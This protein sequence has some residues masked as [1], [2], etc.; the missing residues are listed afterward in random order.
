[1]SPK[2]KDESFENMM[3][4]F[5][6]KPG[7]A[8]KPP[9]IDQSSL[10]DAHSKYSRTLNDLEAL[11]SK[12]ET[13]L[14]TDFEKCRLEYF[15]VDYLLFQLPK[16]F[17]PKKLLERISSLKKNMDQ[18]EIQSAHQQLDKRHKEDLLEAGKSSKS[19]EGFWDLEENTGLKPKN[20]VQVEENGVLEEEERFLKDVESD[21]K[22]QSDE[23][24]FFKKEL[25]QTEPSDS[26]SEEEKDLE[27]LQKLEKKE[28][29]EARKVKTTDSID[30]VKESLDESLPKKPR[31]EKYVS[32]QQEK[33]KKSINTGKADISRSKHIQAGQEKYVVVAA[34]NLAHHISS[35]EL[36][37]K[38]MDYFNKKAYKYAIMCF[39][40]VLEIS[41]NNFAAR[42]RI[43]QAQEEFSKNQQN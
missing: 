10:E 22:T 12:L 41:P 32:A 34:P 3:K 31:I 30:K 7:T 25:P 8:P 36:Y 13:L 4:E 38:G 26:K 23:T 21:E 15:N 29:E 2:P 5:E 37:D 42:I 1:M 17:R 43:K 18:K 19:E 28:A 39:K 9:K 27:A 24:R 20:P 16:E 40:K 14:V 35:S 33:L 11:V 6:K